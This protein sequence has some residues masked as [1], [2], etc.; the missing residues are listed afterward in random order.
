[1]TRRGF[2]MVELAIVLSISVLLIPMVYA[3]AQAIEEVHEL[4]LWHLRS[5]DQLHS[6]AEELRLDERGG[7]R[8]PGATLAWQRGTCR[9][10]YRVDEHGVLLREAS[11]ACGGTRALATGVTTLAAVE[12][13]VELELTHVLRPT[14]QER[15][16][17]FIPLE[18]K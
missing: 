14:R 12:G 17:L 7:E 6:V 5:A 11:V 4:A 10:V 9:V 13:G 8:Q 2:T 18:A 1:M 15:T 16:H 3:G